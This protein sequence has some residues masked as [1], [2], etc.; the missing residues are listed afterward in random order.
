[1]KSSHINLITIENKEL[2]HIFKE[3]TVRMA[4]LNLSIQM[5]FIRFIPPAIDI[6]AQHK[7]IISS[8][9][10]LDQLHLNRGVLKRKTYQRYTKVKKQTNS[11]ISQCQVPLQ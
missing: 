8:I 1:M 9:K 5:Q 10:P 4:M 7:V 3:K 6:C 2:L 11:E